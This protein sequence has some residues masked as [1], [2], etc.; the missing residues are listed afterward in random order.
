MAG[1]D[2]SGGGWQGGMGVEGGWDGKAGRWL[3][4]YV[5]LLL[6]LRSNQETLWESTGFRWTTSLPNTKTILL[7][8]E[9]NVVT[10]AGGQ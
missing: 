7:I 10:S 8:Q 9:G 1:R 6:V 4:N 5:T 3:I 2:A